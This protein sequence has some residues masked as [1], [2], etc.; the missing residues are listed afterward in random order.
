MERHQVTP[1]SAFWLFV[2]GIG[3]GVAGTLDGDIAYAQ[4]CE[5]VERMQRIEQGGAVFVE[6]VEAAQ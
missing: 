3:L 2:I 5:R 6:Y 4:E 1:R